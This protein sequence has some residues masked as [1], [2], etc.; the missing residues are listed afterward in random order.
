MISVLSCVLRLSVSISLVS[1]KFLRQVV[2]FCWLAYLPLCFASLHRSLSLSLFVCLSVCPPVCQPVCLSV[3]LCLSL[4]PSL[5][6]LSL[7]SLSPSLSLSVCLSACQPAYLSICL[8]VSVS[9]SLPPS[10]PLC[11][12]LSTRLVSVWRPLRQLFL[13]QRVF[14]SVLCLYHCLSS[15]L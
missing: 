11:L 2:F 5:P 6:L 8:S 3:C 13:G 7:P 1:W 9:L 15:S 4:P 14:L 12:S 10:P